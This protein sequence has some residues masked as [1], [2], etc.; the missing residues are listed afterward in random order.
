MRI[1]VTTLSLLLFIS[2][3]F[4]QTRP[5]TD[6][7]ESQRLTALGKRNIRAHDPSTIIRCGDEY[8]F[9]CTGRGVRSFHSKDLEHWDLGPRVFEK[10]PEWNAKVVPG[11]RE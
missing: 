10:A 8:W 7:A 9:F 11:T 2:N 1:L 4:A 3:A 6:P 5:T